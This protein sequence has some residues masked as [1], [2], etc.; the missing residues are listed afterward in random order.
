MRK[1]TAGIAGVALLL[2]AGPALASP[3]TYTEQTTGSGQLGNNPFTDALVTLTVHADTAN[4]TQD[5]LGD[6]QNI[7]ETATVN[8][9]GLGTATFTLG[10]GGVMVVDNPYLPGAGIVK[11]TGGTILGT[12]NDPAFATYDLTTAIGPITNFR[13]INPSQTFATDQGDFALT[14]AGESTFTATTSGVPEPA[15][16]ALLGLGAVGL[17]ARRRRA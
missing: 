17:I 8:V 15:S 14:S 7:A 6:F 3:I 2:A 1:Q 16:L 13:L 12:V 5:F 10:P 9:T 11:T 4:V